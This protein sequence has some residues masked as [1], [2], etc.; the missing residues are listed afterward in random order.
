MKKEKTIKPISKISNT[1]DTSKTNGKT[2]PKFL[3]QEYG[4]PK[5]SKLKNKWRKP[6]GIDSKKAEKKRGK[7]AVPSIG[8]RKSASE[9]GLH[10]GF[11]AVRV[12]NEWGLETIDN[13]SQAA[14][15][16]SCV[17][18]RKRNSIIERANELKI[19]ILNP[20]RGET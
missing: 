20:K 10:Y 7:G 16:A 19:T 13:K 9:S 18:R 3:R 4:R 17:G 14:V 15:I 12:F 1:P 8:Y 2:K 11:E 6:K 5:K